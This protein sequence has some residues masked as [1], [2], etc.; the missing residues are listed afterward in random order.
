MT[1]LKDSLIEKIET[2]T[3]AMRPRWYFILETSF[4]TVGV[5]LTA[6]VAI[7][8][9][10]FIFFALT[11]TGLSLAPGFGFGG[12]LF[13]IVT[14]P[15]L[16]I[17]LTGL[18]LT[19]LALLVKHYTFSYRQPLVYSLLGVVGLVLII[20]GLLHQVAFHERMERMNERHN[21]PGLTPLYRGATSERPREITPGEI[22][23]VSATS[24]TLRTPENETFIVLTTN[25]TRGSD[26]LPLVVGAN[27]LVFGE[28]STSTITAKG[29]R[30]LLHNLPPLRPQ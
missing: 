22:M 21:L 6:L 7:Y 15:W 27:V 23:S 26:D 29:I 20:S 2:G 9:L 18:F 10:S 17:L 4:F 14:S 25:R 30:P 3:V 24:F 1:K 28:R 5:I 8:L 11:K 16:L 12:L 13:F 19:L